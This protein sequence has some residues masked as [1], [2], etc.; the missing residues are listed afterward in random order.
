MVNEHMFRAAAKHW[1]HVGPNH[2]N[3]LGAALLLPRDAGGSK[4][5]QNPELVEIGHEP[6]GRTASPGSHFHY[7]EVLFDGQLR[8]ARF[9]CQHVANRL[10][11]RALSKTT[12]FV[13]FRFRST[14]PWPSRSQ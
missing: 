3:V 10:K 2:H 13:T 6:D 9:V 4:L 5:K 8:P 7:R 12:E 14:F 1:F 11:R